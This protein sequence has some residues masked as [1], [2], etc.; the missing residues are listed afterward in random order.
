MLWANN[1][2]GG[3]RL[4]ANELPRGQ[5]GD[6]YRLDDNKED[7]RVHIQRHRTFHANAVDVET[8]QGQVP[9]RPLLMLTWETLRRSKSLVR[10]LD[11]APGAFQST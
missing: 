4:R 6:A 1:V 7:A 11:F 2:A 9:L 8:Q 3:R 10:L 5:K